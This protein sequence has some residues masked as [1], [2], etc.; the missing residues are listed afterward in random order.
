MK[1]LRKLQRKTL[2]P[3]QI[4]GYIATLLVGVAIVLVALQSYRDLR[5]LLTQQTDVFKAHTVTVSKNVTMFKTANKEGIYF[6]NKELASL[7]EQPFVKDVAHFTSAQFNTEAAISFAGQT[8]RTD[9]FFESVPDEYLDVESS[10]WKWDSTSDFLPLVIPEDYLNLYNFGFAESQSLPVVSEGMLSQVTFTVVVSGNGKRRVY[11][12]RIVGLSGKINSILVPDDFLQWANKEFG[13]ISEKRSSRLLVEFTDAS[14]ERIPAYFEGRGLNISQSELESSKIA[15]F[16]R[17]GM[18]FVIVI[19]MI[20]IILSV[21]F[22][23]MSL[24]LIVQRNRDLFINLYKIGYS[25]GQIARFYRVVISILTIIDIVIAALLASWFRSIYTDKL[26]VL[27][28]IDQTGS[29]IWIIASIS[30]IVLLVLYNTLIM[31]SIKKTV[32]V[33]KREK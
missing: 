28:D 19:A 30:A 7:K 26:K 8:M 11:D 27:F 15:F 9:F 6:D 12:S 16:F 4:A 10:E 23:I 21:A 13:D 18:I 24:N 17:L 5:P 20:I 2:I 22:I 33:V 32:G 3:A 25:C 1:M 14:D 31:H 29:L